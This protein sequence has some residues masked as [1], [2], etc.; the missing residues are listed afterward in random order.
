MKYS[1]K[2]L[3]LTFL[4]TLLTPPVWAQGKLK[5]VLFLGNSYTEV[6]NLPQM[7]VEMA[8]SSNDSILVDSYTP[9]GYRLKNHANDLNSVTKIAAGNWDFVVLQEQSQMPSFP[10]EEVIREVF[11]YTRT[12][13]S[14]IHVY[15]PCAKTI[16]YRTWGRKNGDAQNCLS[17][18]PVCTYAGMDSLLH[19]RYRMMADSNNAILAPAGAVWRQIRQQY[20]EIELYQADESHPALTGTYAAACAIYSVILRKSPMEINYLAG[21]NVTTVVKLQAASELVVFDS[22]AHWNVGLLDPL[23]HFTY[24]PIDGK[25]YQFTNASV[26]AQSYLW[27]FGDGDTSTELNPIHEYAAAGKYTVTLKVLNCH[28][29]DSIYSYLTIGSSGVHQAKVNPERIQLLTNP[30]SDV[31]EI[32]VQPNQM[33]EE[34]TVL[35]QTGNVVLTGII[36]SQHT[37]ISVTDLVNGIYL[38]HV[39]S[40][41]QKTIKFIKHP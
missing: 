6:N 1:S 12:L 2:I 10:D 23:A 37:K 4:L 3:M 5:R 20:P 26:N 39:G 13:D 38:L 34:Y 40:G 36:S 33:G 31:L 16:F 41:K 19:L 8:K 17:W 25:K 21:L 14:L 27:T 7:L 15:N 18:P 9:G 22:L 28:I 32:V 29:T 30:V 11:P 24:S 35:N